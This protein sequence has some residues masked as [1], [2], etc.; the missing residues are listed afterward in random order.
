MI[1]LDTNQLWRNK[2]LDTPVLSILRAVAKATGHRLALP[3]LVIEEF[4]ATYEH[5]IRA[6]GAEIERKVAKLAGLAPQWQ[7]QPP[8]TWPYEPLKRGGRHR[9]P[10]L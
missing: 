6:R 4:L 9:V 2:T 10:G 7:Q 8:S 3:A 1:I 5:E